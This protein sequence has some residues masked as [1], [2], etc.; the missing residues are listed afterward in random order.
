[1]SV[2]PVISC[3]IPV[4]NDRLH[5]PRAVKSVLDQRS[6]AQVVLVD[7][8]SSDGSRELT[9]EMARGDRRIVALPLP[10]NRG[11]AYA[12]NIGAAAADAP[13]ITFLDQDDEHAPGWYDHA[14]DLLRKDPNAAAVRG[15]IELMEIPPELSISR[16][17]PRWRAMMNSLLWNIVMHKSVYE[18]LGGCPTSPVFRTRE[19]AEDVA[20]VAALTRHFNV[21]MTDFLATRHYVKPDGATAYFLKRT[22]VVGTH[23]EFIEFT[24]AERRGTLDESILE[25]QAR[26]AVNVGML[27]GLLKPRFRGVRDW[28]SRGAARLLRRFSRT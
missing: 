15:E 3:V 4:F 6:D 14:V 17:D 13:Y 5:L 18:V 11:Q 22:R 7:D 28:M 23:F 19:G 12:R 2:A 24:D 9:L 27:R 8:G 10:D 25:F 16:A 21:A 26:A 20:L 1:M